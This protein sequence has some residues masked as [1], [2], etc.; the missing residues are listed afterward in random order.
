MD[1]DEN[2][3]ANHTEEGRGSSEAG[4]TKATIEKEN[5]EESRKA[6]TCC[7]ERSI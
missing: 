6:C 3:K 1:R 2:T 7:S 5:Q 4:S